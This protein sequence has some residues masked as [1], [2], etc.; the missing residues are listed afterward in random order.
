M[1][2]AVY[3][4]LMIYDAQSLKDKRSVLK[5]LVT[6]LKQRYNVSV[7]EI[8]H[9]NVWQRS[10]L[11]IVTVASD[12]TVADKELQ[13]ALAF[14]DGITEVERTITNYEWL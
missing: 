11:A 2:G 3:C 1:I 4:E 9:Q 12:K 8:N 7:S 5:S 13:R 14:I 6:K 10:E